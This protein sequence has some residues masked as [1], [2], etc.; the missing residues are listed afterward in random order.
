MKD[1]PWKHAPKTAETKAKIS[2]S[3]RGKNR[4]NAHARKPPER[5]RV[6]VG[7]SVAPETFAAL[8]A[9]A[10]SRGMSMGKAADA[11]FFRGAEKRVMSEE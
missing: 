1:E 6:R 5:H 9:Y 4:G 8:K 11:L 10:E 7:L 2:A 3:M